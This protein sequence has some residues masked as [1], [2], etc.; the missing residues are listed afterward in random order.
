MCVSGCTPPP[1]PSPQPKVLTFFPL[2]AL[3]KG[4]ET[5]NFQ[6]ICLRNGWQKSLPAECD[7]EALVASD[8]GGQTSQALL[9]GPAHSHQEGIAS[10]GADHT[11]DLQQ[12]HHGVLTRY[13]G[14][15]LDSGIFIYLAANKN[16]MIASNRQT[17]VK[18]SCL[19]PINNF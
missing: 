19:F 13:M 10:V 4:N 8:V 15:F 17:A 14:T 5:D 11:R 3:P 1:T 9:T 18:T 7:L 6:R 2:S 12:V 16:K